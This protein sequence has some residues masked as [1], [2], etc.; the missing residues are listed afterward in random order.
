VTAVPPVNAV[1]TVSDGP[2]GVFDSGVGGLTVVGALLRR[3]PSERILYVADQAHVPYGGRP[4]SEI[5]GFASGISAFLA[6]H[7]CRAIVM[8][9]NISSATALT[10]V[11]ADLAPLPVLGV[12]EAAARRAAVDSEEPRIGVLATEGTVRTGAY[13]ATIRGLNANAFVREVACPRFVPLVEAGS[14]ETEE[15]LDAAREYLAPLAEA[16]CDRVVLG[17]T[18]YP[19]LLPALKRVAGELFSRSLAFIDPAD[20]V[21]DALCAVTAMKEA[22]SSSASPSLLVTTSEADTFDRQSRVFLPGVSCEIGEARWVERR[23]HFDC[24]KATAGTKGT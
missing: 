17:C 5:C 6:G 13:G 12:I 15:A 16:R 21:A 2:L 4:L 10:S 19:F 7:G 8:A 9:C 23:L 18:H 11:R 3:F 1:S 14:L 20:E 22:P 24:G